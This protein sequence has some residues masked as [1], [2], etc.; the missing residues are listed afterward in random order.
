MRTVNEALW[1]RV[2]RVT[3]G[4]VLLSL[5]WSGAVGGGWGVALKV[6]G[7]LPLATGLSGWCV[8]YALLGYRTNREIRPAVEAA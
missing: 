3:L 6:V 2:A 8:L 4:V 5:G 7:L 1:D